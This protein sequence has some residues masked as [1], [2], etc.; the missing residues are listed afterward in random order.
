MIPQHARRIRPPRCLAVPFEL[1]RPLGVPN[2]PEFQLQVLRAALVL[3]AEDTPDPVFEMYATDAPVQV[4]DAGPWACPVNFSSATA[5][6]SRLQKILNEI[7][8][9]RPWHDRYLSASGRTSIGLSQLAV[10]DIPGYLLEFLENSGNERILP[11]LSRAEGLKCA[12]EDLKAYY[13]EAAVAQPGQA[14]SREIE[15]WYWNQCEAGRLVRDLKRHCMTDTDPIVRL[16]A[17]RT[18]VPHTQQGH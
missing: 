9:L 12:A 11:G 14:K 3:L 18:L 8:L 10:E 15:S 2:D 16:L 17:E 13:N 5:E 4:E 6:D 1:G 7:H